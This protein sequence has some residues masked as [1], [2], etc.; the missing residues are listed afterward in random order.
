MSQSGADLLR[1]DQ[2]RSDLLVIDDEASVWQEVRDPARQDA[3]DL[4]LT[5]AID[6]LKRLTRL[7]KVRISVCALSEPF[8]L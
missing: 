6:T 5:T 3:A 7:W 8:N 4:H 2:S 1:Q